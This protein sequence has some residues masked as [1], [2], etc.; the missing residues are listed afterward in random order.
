MQPA[1][2]RTEPAPRRK[3]ALSVL[4]I[5]VSGGLITLL[6]AQADPR[7]IWEVW[8]GIDLRLLALALLIQLLGIALSAAKWGVLLRAR[9]QAQPFRWLLGLYLIGQFASNFLPTVVGGDA[10]RVVQLGRRIGSYSAASASV[11][12]ERL[13]GFL[14]LAALANLALLALLQTG[15]ISVNPSLVLLTVGFGLAA[16]GGLLA[17]FWAA[18]FQRVVGAYLPAFARAPL[19]RV[20]DAL[21][22]YAPRGRQLAL[23]LGLSLL[24]QCL[25][26]A[27]HMVCG[28]ALGLS[29]PLLL[30]T[31]M[32]T[33]TDMVGLAPIFVNNLG[34]R[35]MV[36]LLYLGPIGVGQA[37]AVALALLIFGVRL[38]VSVLGGL[39]MAFGGL[40]T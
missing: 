12:L 8:R 27:L 24:F 16:L 6:V 20:A 7:Q 28:L 21:T 4:R 5:V 30:Y 18:R 31:L 10:V 9:G 32:A 38:L 19:Q 2:A 36:F 29:A 35:E 15:L 17:V 23:V 39:V 33:N 22:D 14:A 25:W 37:Q 26:V 13:T 1:A 3:L 11:F 40:E 34:A